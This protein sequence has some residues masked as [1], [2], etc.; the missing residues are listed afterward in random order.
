MSNPQIHVRRVHGQDLEKIAKI[1][2]SVFTGN[3]DN[4]EA[5]LKWVKTLFSAFPIYQYFA[6]EV[7]GQFAGYIGW[8]VHGGFLRSSPTVELEQLG[9][10]K[11]FQ[12]QGLALKL[13]NQS[14]EILVE[15]VKDENNR[16]ESGITFFVWGYF[17]NQNAH[18]VYLKWFGQPDGFRKQYADRAEV[19]L[20]RTIPLTM[21]SRQ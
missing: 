16:I 13:I 15:W 9:I 5:A 11:E 14:V 21:E 7:D 3:R 4:L 12:A 6:I 17:S 10:A 20:K 19:M 8:Q 18:S 1:N 2:A